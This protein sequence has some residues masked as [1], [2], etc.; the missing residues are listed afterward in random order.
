MTIRRITLALYAWILAFLL[1]PVA[2][3]ASDGTISTGSQL[4][5]ITLTSIIVGSVLPN[6]TAVIISPSWRSEVRGLV[7]F[8]ICT[9]AG[10]VIAFLQGDLTN[11][12]D[13]GTSI[14]SVLVTSQ[15][16][17]ATLWK[18]S[19]IAPTIEQKTTLTSS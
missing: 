6:L 2:A 19:G 7:T 8:G 11:V 9:A 16:L 5:D 15:V 18:P 4:G 14:V 13:V 10:G 17:Y 3:F 12:T 1:Y